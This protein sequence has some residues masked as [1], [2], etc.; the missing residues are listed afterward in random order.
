[1]MGQQC[2]SE[3]LFY[4]FRIED[5]IPENHLLRAIDRLVRFDS[6]R[7]KLEPFYSE[8]GKPSIDRNCSFASC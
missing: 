1:M 6:I 7:E 8:M 4:F 3:S 2:R 5:H